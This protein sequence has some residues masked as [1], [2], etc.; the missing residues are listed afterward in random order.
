MYMF[1][2]LNKI[3]YVRTFSNVIIQVLALIYFDIGEFAMLFIANILANLVS[4]LLVFVNVRN[5][6]V[7]LDSEIKFILISMGI[8]SSCLLIT[9]T[10]ISIL[11]NLPFIYGIVLLERSIS[12]VYSIWIAKEAKDTSY[13]NFELFS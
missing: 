10:T 4:F 2:K 7:L 13:Y 8:L 5:S 11:Q 9:W 6:A 1:N 12:P 3:I